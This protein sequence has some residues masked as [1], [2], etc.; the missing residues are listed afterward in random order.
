MTYGFLE[1]TDSR[2]HISPNL[3]A[4]SRADGIPIKLACQFHSDSI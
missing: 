1:D 3:E 2:G 4:V